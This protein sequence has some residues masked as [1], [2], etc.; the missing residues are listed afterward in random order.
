MLPGCPGC[1]EF[2][3]MP[4]L[5]RPLAPGASPLSFDDLTTDL[6]A[7]ASEYLR[8]RGFETPKLIATVATTED[9]FVKELVNPFIEGFVD[10]HG[11]VHKFIGD[12][13][14]LRAQL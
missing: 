6:P 4:R 12:S 8:A 10:L 3:R 11:T 2:A 13:I 5:G 1:A 9:N 7:D 14:L